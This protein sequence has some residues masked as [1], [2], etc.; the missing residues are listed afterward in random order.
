MRVC[1]SRH[2][3]IHL[4]KVIIYLFAVLQTLILYSMSTERRPMAEWVCSN[5][6]FR[7]PWRISF[8][9]ELDA[10]HEVTIG[11][12]R[13]VTCCVKG[14]SRTAGGGEKRVEVIARLASRLCSFSP[15]HSIVIATYPLAIPRCTLSSFRMNA[16]FL[17]FNIFFAPFIKQFPLHYT[18]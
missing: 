12:I 13:T 4:V 7:Q 15:P 11:L 6:V 3:L 1:H 8:S 2:Y 14:N 18:M 10:Y 5:M 17:K 16:L 9:V